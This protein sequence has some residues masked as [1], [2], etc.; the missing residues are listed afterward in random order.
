[1]P[2]AHGGLGLGR[3]RPRAPCSKRPGAPPRRSR[4]WR[5][6][7]S[8]RRS[9][10]T[11][12]R[13]RS[14]IDG[15]RASPRARP[16]WRSASIDAPY[17]A[18][19][20]ERGPLHPPARR[21]APRARAAAPSRSR[22]SPR[23]TARAAS[24]PSRGA[25]AP[26]P[27][28][29]SGDAARRAAARAFDRGALATA[30]VLVGL[31]RQML[32]LTV[33]Y[34]KVRQQ[35]GKPI[36]SFQAVKHHLANALVAVELARPMVLRAAYAVRARRPRRA[37]ARLDGQ[38][39]RLGRGP[40]HRAGRAPVPRRHRLRGRARPA[41][42]DEACLGARVGVGRRRVAPGPRSAPRSSTRGRSRPRT[43]RA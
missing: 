13:P 14:A 27:R 28:I 12:R 32:D 9:C 43:G 22:P 19:A 31:A 26:P 42:L 23:S 37:D 39:P 16:C 36:G 7:P 30:A 3:A 4:S 17:V 25:R 29:A 1:M 6:R 11:R 34:A 24:P 20:G 2:E 40:R 35:F 21:R 33:E 18:F 10:W 5:R 15:S 41:P 8:A 38:G